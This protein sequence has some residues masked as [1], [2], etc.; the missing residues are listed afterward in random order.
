[1]PLQISDRLGIAAVTASLRR[2][3]FGEFSAPA[4]TGHR[5][6]QERTDLPLLREDRPSLTWPNKRALTKI[7][8]VPRTSRSL[9][10]P[11]PEWPPTVQRQVA[12]DA[13]AHNK[14]LPVLS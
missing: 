2:S 13:D 14:G 8:I 6:R 10:Y 3:D 7:L 4:R 11:A 12:L 5:R 1:M 9:L